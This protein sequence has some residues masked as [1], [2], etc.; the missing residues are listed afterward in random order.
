MKRFWNKNGIW[1]I[2]AA[3]VIMVTLSL[4]S[5]LGSGSSILENAAGVIASPFRSAAAA[6]TGWFSGISEQ[7]EDV[8][9]LQPIFGLMPD[10]ANL[11]SGCSFH[12]RCPFATEECSKVDPTQVEIEPGHFVKCLLYKDGK[13][14]E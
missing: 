6:V 8:D 12:P 5:V 4:L 13:Q 9:R 7:F 14:G 11:P 10:P 3:A 1:L 2:A